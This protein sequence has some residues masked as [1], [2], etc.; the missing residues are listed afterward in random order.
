M[1]DPCIAGPLKV[2]SFF[3]SVGGQDSR[4]CLHKMKVESFFCEL[5]SAVILFMD[6]VLSV[7]LWLFFYKK[8]RR[9]MFTYVNCFNSQMSEV[10]PE[11]WCY[12][13]VLNLNCHN[14]SFWSFVKKNHYI[15]I[16]MKTNDQQFVFMLICC[17]MF[18]K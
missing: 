15:F 3:F 13:T 9:I 14:L 18:D 4:C 6:F 10:W 2:V 1:S 8:M 12:D 11:D 17:T 16:G 7:T 5:R